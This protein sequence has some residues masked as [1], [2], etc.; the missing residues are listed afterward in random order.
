MN[1]LGHLYF[2]NNDEQLM[3]AN[4]LGDFIKG[5][6]LSSYSTIIQKGVHLHRTIDNYID[7]H[8][9]VLELLQTLYKDL[10]KV[11]GIAID[12]Y[13][14]YLLAKNWNNYSNIP[15]TRFVHQ[16]ENASINRNSFNNS[17]FWLVIDK[18][19][20]GKWLHETNTIYGLTKASEGVSNIISFPNTLTDA[21]RVFLEQQ[22]SIEKVFSN[23]MQEAIPFFKDYFQN[24]ETNVLD[25]T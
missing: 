24:L 12:L 13:F 6:D 3:Y 18:M 15:L 17:H 23:F 10:P 7:T 19:K 21:P 2:S 25:A 16:F 1:F 22:N 11:S 14:D 8:P 5:K 9:L 4:L 20:A